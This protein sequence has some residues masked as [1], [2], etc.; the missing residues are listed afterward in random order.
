MSAVRA[1]SRIRPPDR[2]GLHHGQGG[3]VPDID[4]DS[5]PWTVV[6]SNDKKRARTEAMRSVLARFDYVD[7]DP[8][9]VGEPDP[10]IV[11]SAFGSGVVD[12]D[13][14]H[15]LPPDA[16][17]AEGVSFQAGLGQL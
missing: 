2:Y 14:V 9:I 8:E 10:R 4:T 17:R 13:D 7:K 12:Q 15:G 5:A 16:E 6:K 11:G 1:T 3:H